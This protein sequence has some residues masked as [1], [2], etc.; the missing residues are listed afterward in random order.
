M[1]KYYLVDILKFLFALGVVGLHT[2]FLLSYKYG[3]YVHTI[4]FRLGVPYFFIISGYLLAINIKDKEEKDKIK[5]FISKLL[6]IYLLLSIIYAIMS[7][8]RFDSF[9][10]DNI[11]Y[12]VWYVITGR[13]LSVMWYVG[14]LIC[15]AVVLLHMNTKKKLKKSIV[16][17]FVLYLIGLLFNTYSFLLQGTYFQ[18][19]LNFLISEFNNN[20]NFV[21]L[22]YFY[23][24]LGYYIAK[25][26][27][28]NI[29]S[30]LVIKMFIFIF[31]FV[32]LTFETRLV[33]SHLDIVVNYEYY[34]AHILIIPLLLN[35]SVLFT[36]KLQTGILRNLSKYIYYFHYLIIYVF[37]FLNKYNDNQIMNNNIK[38]YLYTVIG[39]IILSLLYIEIKKVIK[40]FK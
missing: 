26:N 14:A 10:L 17:A 33:R 24:S 34:L 23:F 12:Q 16:V 28:E 31:S 32:L 1:K 39:T 20:S 29:N 4:I 18:P 25:Y 35:F 22:G 40:K 19:F 5:K 21:F 30:H 7:M 2:G 3:F 37:I 15:S 13:S 11:I 36:G 9:N 27:N 6:P 8:I 38:F